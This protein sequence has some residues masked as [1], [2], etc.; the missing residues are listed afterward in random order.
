MKVINY[1]DG[2]YS[3]NEFTS[4]LRGYR[5]ELRYITKLEMSFLEPHGKRWVAQ[6]QKHFFR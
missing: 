4:A 2:G 6:I 5:L 3:N 1:L